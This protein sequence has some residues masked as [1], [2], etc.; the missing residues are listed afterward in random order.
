MA[1]LKSKVSHLLDNWL[2]WQVKTKQLSEI[3]SAT[4]PAVHKLLDEVK[5]EEEMTNSNGLLIPVSLSTV[6]L[7][8][9]DR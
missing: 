7:N 8:S 2:E 1:S 9:R 5:K 3:E 4:R 6:V